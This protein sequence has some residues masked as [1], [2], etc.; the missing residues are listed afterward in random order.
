MKYTKKEQHRYEVLKQYRVEDL[1]EMVVSNERAQDRRRNRS[2]CSCDACT[3]ARAQIA[4][5]R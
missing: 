5:H 4:S 2:A 3:Q 1:A